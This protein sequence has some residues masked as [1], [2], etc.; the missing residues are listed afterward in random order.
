MEQLEGQKLYLLQWYHAIFHEKMMKFTKPKTNKS[1]SGLNFIYFNVFSSCK[2]QNVPSI[3]QEHK[4][5][6]YLT[7]YFFALDI[8][9]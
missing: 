9:R 8:Y 4:F 3:L 7:N 5:L 6:K 2:E 1:L